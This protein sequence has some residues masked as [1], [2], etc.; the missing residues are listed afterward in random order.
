MKESSQLGQG[1][2]EDQAQDFFHESVPTLN[3]RDLPEVAAA[4]WAESGH[5]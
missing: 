2:P 5:D 1:G 3:T 4:W